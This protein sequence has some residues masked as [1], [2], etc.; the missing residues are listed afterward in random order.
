MLEPPHATNETHNT[1][2]PGR[3]N[4]FHRESEACPHATETLHETKPPKKTTEGTH[5]YLNPFRVATFAHVSENTTFCPIH[6]NSTT[7]TTT[8]N[9]NTNIPPPPFPP[10]CVIESNQLKTQ[11]NP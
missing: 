3:K 2:P 6:H 8:T 11:E 7:D 10:L 1:G 9:T 5:T 4:Y